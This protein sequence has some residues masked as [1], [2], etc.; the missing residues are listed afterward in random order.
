MTDSEIK[1]Q[2][3]I[4]EKIE[5][6]ANQYIS[7]I[8]TE[9]LSKIESSLSCIETLSQ[10]NDKTLELMQELGKKMKSAARFQTCMADMFDKFDK[11]LNDSM[12]NL[13]KD[14]KIKGGILNEI[15]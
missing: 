3:T 1:S 2:V 11:Q 8:D 4:A 12:E 5:Q 10:K 7:C 14:N 13:N 6:I 15:R 9:Q